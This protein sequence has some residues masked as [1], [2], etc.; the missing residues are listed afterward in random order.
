[1]NGEA[2]PEYLTRQEVMALVRLRKTRL[3]EM[4]RDG[5]F[6]APIRLGLRMIAWREADVRRW[7][8]SRET[9]T[10]GRRE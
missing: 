6:P 4:V 10:W 9:V 5:L 3:Y 2:K 7:L 1:M 8:E